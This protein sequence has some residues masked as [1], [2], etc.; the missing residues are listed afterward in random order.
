LLKDT[1]EYEH[2]LG[3]DH[4]LLSTAACIDDQVRFIEARQFDRLR[5]S[6]KIPLQTP[7][8]CSFT[9]IQSPSLIP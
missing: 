7:L 9:L 2:R 5:Q 4:H 1:I 8:V 3:T 6:T